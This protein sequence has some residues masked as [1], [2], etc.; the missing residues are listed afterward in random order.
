MQAC[1]IP[2]QQNLQCAVPLIQ[3]N[4]KAQRALSA[5]HHIASLLFPKKK[6]NSILKEAGCSGFDGVCFGIFG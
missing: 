1:G 6:F 2:A 3:T 4:P 5:V